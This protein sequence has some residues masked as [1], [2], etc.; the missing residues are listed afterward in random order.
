MD[1]LD[2]NEKL[3]KILKRDFQEHAEIE[4]CFSCREV[5]PGRFN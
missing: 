2:Q 4:K 1:R 5:T 3:I